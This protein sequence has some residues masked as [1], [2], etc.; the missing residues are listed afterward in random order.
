MDLQATEKGPLFLQLIKATLLRSLRAQ[1]NREGARRS[2]FYS[3]LGL[4]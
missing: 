1:R 2:F 4:Y 3:S